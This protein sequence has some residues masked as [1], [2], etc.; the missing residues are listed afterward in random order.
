VYSAPSSQSDFS[1]FINLFSFP[2]MKF[3]RQ[4]IGFILATA[5]T[6]SP[7]SVQEK[8]DTVSGGLIPVPNGIPDLTAYT[9]PLTDILDGE[10]SLQE[11]LPVHGLKTKKDTVSGG[12]IPVPNGIPDLTAYTKPLTD[13]L[14]GEGSIQDDLPVHGFKEKRDASSFAQGQPISADGK[15][16]P[17]LGGTNHQLDLQNPDNLGRTPTDNGNVPNLKWSFSDSKT[18]L[19]KGG[20]V[21]EQVITDLPS[22]TDVSAAQQHIKKGALRELHWHRVVRFIYRALTGHN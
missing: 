22:S 6:A 3:S 17:I 12:L 10:G 20:W 13:I 7:V 1:L 18:R 2:A 9:K 15:G 19:L 11:D 14:D 21:R 5:A 16:G 8:R 4:A